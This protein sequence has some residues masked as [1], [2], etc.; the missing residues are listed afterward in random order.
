MGD[1]IYNLKSH[2]IAFMVVSIQYL[3]DL[4]Q[5][6]EISISKDFRF[7]LIP[8]QL[9]ELVANGFIGNKGLQ[10][11]LIAADAYVVAL[12]IKHGVSSVSR[13][14]IISPV[15]AAVNEYSH[16]HTIANI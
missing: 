8:V 11:A 9:R 12:F 14:I 1:F 2:F 10:P 5:I 16:A 6:A 3:V 13:G 15:Y 7:N 4:F